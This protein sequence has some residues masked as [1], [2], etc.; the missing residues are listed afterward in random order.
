MKFG[1]THIEKLKEQMY[2][3]RPKKKFALLPVLLISGEYLWMEWYV[4][5]EQANY[6]LEE[7]RFAWS[8]HKREFNPRNLD[9]FFTYC[10]EEFQ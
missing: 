4:K 7:E 2:N 9:Y 3:T 6:I 10:P 8:A 1:K 5:G